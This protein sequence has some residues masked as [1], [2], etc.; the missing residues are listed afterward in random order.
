MKKVIILF[1]I[2]VLTSCEKYPIKFFAPKEV[3]NIKYD[4]ILKKD[5]TYYHQ[6]ILTMHKDTV[7]TYRC[8]RLLSPGQPIYAEFI[9]SQNFEKYSQYLDF[10]FFIAI[11]EGFNISF[12]PQ[13]PLWS[14]RQPTTYE[15]I[16]ILSHPSWETG[17]TVLYAGISCNLGIPEP[18]DFIVTNNLPDS[19]YY[20]YDWQSSVHYDYM[21]YNADSAILTFT[22]EN[23]I[24]ADTITP[25]DSAYI[26]FHDSP[27]AK[28]YNVFPLQVTDTI[29]VLDDTIFNYRVG[30]LLKNQHCGEDTYS[31]RIHKSEII[32]KQNETNRHQW[33][34]YEYDE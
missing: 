23:P 7:F 4:P 27:I 16:E 25:I 24:E 28:G 20:Y 22:I 34:I 5:T 18:C 29:S 19:I 32:S 8:S 12:S 15:F 2:I 9:P 33:Q 26:I 3:H 17:D 14:L 11:K 10:T 30:A 31:V 6:Y 21:R 13:L 1:V